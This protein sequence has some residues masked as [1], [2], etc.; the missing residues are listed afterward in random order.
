MR[1][2]AP[3]G[4][5]A[6]TAR[7]LDRRL[8][9]AIALN[10]A[11]VVAEV[12]GGFVSGSLALLS[13]ALHNSTDAAALALALAARILARRGP[14]MRHT[15]GWRRLEVIAALVNGATLL[16]VATL[17]VRSA[18]LRLQHPHP[19]EQHLMLMVAGFGLLANLGSML[20]L[21]SHDHNDL[22]TRAAFLHLLQDTLSSIV[23]VAAGALAHT[24]IGPWLDPA[25]SLLVIALIVRSTFQLLRRALHILMQGTPPSVVIEELRQDVVTRFGLRDMRHIHVWELGTGYHV[26]TAHLVST[27]DEL[28]TVVRLVPQIRDY[29]RREWHIEHATLE[30]EAE[31]SEGCSLEAK[32]RD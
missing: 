26:L 19:V 12:I 30:V 17:V 4:S 7:Q 25:A 5:L 2:A 3:Q 32:Q 27:P 13:D 6:K 10:T 22:N 31:P 1:C 23:V 16:V 11:S 18:V 8:A 24:R 9:A 21:R 14:S 28:L 20:L 29:L 15:F